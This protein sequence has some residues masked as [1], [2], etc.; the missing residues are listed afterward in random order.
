MKARLCRSRW[1]MQVCTVASGK[2]AVIASGKPFRPST[3]ASRMSSTPRFRSSF[4]TRSL[5]ARM[6]GALLSKAR[7]GEL[8]VTLPV[9]YRRRP[10]GAVVQDPDEAVRL[11]GG[12]GVERVGPLG[13]ARAVLRHFAGNS[14]AFPRLAQ[15]GP[16][17][18]RIAWV[19][20]TY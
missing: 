12:A 14:L 2:T 10:D 11:A 3:T 13:D 18:G 5:Q 19:R 7:R 15:A 20:P 4:M 9:G 16:E 1:T 17:A 8:A 6:R